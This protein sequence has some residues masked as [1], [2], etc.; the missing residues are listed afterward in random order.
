MQDE[1]ALSS[2]ADR[3]APDP[4]GPGESLAARIGRLLASERYA[5]LATQGE[6]QPYGS[7]VAFAASED[8]SSIVFS[9]PVTTRKFRLLEGCDRVAV[10]VDS[11]SAHASTSASDLMAF[12]A[13]TATGKAV[14]VE[15]GPELERWADVLIRRH[16]H[17][18][19]FVRSPSSA[20]F[21][22][23]VVRYFH[24]CRFQEVGQW[25]P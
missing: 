3:D 13:V 18:A 6:G 22:V 21:R 2:R 15:P 25:T 16:P 5:V 17:L 10:V 20:L 19:P 11:R 4:N 9:T 23:K 8:L 24:V 14:R 12:E 7:L 1:P